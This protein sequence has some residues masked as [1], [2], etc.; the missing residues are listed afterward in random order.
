MSYQENKQ[1]KVGP[2]N[3]RF[4]KKENIYEKKENVNTI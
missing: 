2:I 3:Q 4:K 1:M